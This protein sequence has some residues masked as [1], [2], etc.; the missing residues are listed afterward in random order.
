M[1]RFMT[2][3]FR[4]MTVSFSTALM[5]FAFLPQ[6][7]WAIADTPAQNVPQWAE[8]LTN[9]WV[10][11]ALLTLAF[12]AV[13]VEIFTPTFGIAGFFSI[14]FF[15]LF[16]VSNYLQGNADGT[17]ILLFVGGV[18]L[19]I[20]EVTLEGFGLPGIAGF[21]LV[22][23]GIALSMEDSGH[24]VLSILTATV[25]SVALAVFMVKAGYKSK[26]MSR[27]VLDTANRGED[28]YNSKRDYSH[29]VGKQGYA[30]TVL[31]PAGEIGIGE[32]R[33]DAMTL[34]EFIEKGAPIEV[35]KIE[36]AQ[37]IVRRIT[38]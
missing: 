1:K 16:F 18:V 21:S 14:V 22:F 2:Q 31:R 30:R 9:H 6:V 23:G 37:I 35:H 17:T 19:L 36:N 38:E 25:V 4:W 7:A 34:G 5:L 24:A 20:V 3:R 12:L 32:D 28:G 8:F 26:L 13:V 10:A 33:F 27:S 29:L 15:G 11:T